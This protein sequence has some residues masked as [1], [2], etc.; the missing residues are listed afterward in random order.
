MNK[1]LYI[2]KVPN[3]KKYCLYIIEGNVVKVLAYFVNDETAIEFL[4]YMGAKD[5]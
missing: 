2:G 3:R 1:Q 5:E 4:K